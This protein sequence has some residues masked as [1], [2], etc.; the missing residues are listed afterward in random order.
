MPSVPTWL[1]LVG[2]IWAHCPLAI[3]QQ[4][5]D[6]P[7]F[8]DQLF[9]GLDLNKDGEISGSEARHYIRSTLKEEFGTEQELAEATG[10]FVSNLDKHEPLA[11]NSK[12]GNDHH[13]S[14]TEEEL[15]AHIHNLFKVRGGRKLVLERG[16]YPVCALGGVYGKWCVTQTGCVTCG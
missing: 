10:L 12:G 16:G 11:V 15:E 9:E 5:E 3:S 14:I 7:D 8:A 6:K 13:P 1:L 4:A 2:L